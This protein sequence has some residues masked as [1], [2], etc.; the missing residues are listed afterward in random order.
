MPEPDPARI[1]SFATSKDIGRWLKTN[2]ATES[3]LW[4]KIFKKKTG[5]SSVTWD[6]VVIE[7]LCW[8]WIDGVKKSIDDQ[9]YLQRITPRK[10]RSNWSRRNRELVCPC[11]SVKKF[12]VP[13][14]ADFKL[15]STINRRT[16]KPSMEN[17]S[18]KSEKV[19]IGIDVHKSSYTVACSIDGVI[20][21][22]CRMK[23]SFVGLS[24]YLMKHFDGHEIYTVY[25]AGF[26][27]FELDRF[28]NSRGFK[29]IVINPGSVEVS[30]R[31]RV[32]TDKRDAKKLATQLACGRLK[33][34]RIPSREQ[35]QRR[36]L[37]RTRSQLIR[38]R[39][40]IKNQIRS[41]LHIFSLL[42][43]DDHR[44]MSFKLVGEVMSLN[45]DSELRT[46]LELLISIWKNID[47]QLKVLQQEIRK[48]AKKDPLE[49]VYR[50]LPGAGP[51]SARE[52]SN[53]LGDLQQF[54]NVK[55]LYSFTGLTPS[56]NSSGDKIRRGSISR[57]GSARL[58]HILVEMAWRAIRTDE[59]LR[60]DFNRIA[61]R[62]NK[63]KAIVAIAR[64]L[65][66][67]ARALFRTNTPY[68]TFCSVA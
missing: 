34:I 3:E 9:A 12:F 8:G 59:G 5:I 32:K 52:L 26:S 27:G 22:K 48:Q 30:S 67:R 57:Q 66:G 21:K 38:H 7:S 43:G 24:N 46:S 19:F 13:R 4:V 6:D 25:E 31:D 28:L 20:V 54:P 63:L 68:R 58:R 47:A 56:E 33:G 45:L 49:A 35:E 42:R 41:K 37:T 39:S 55:Q 23:A 65:I 14:N 29:N 11:G 60:R 15:I 18:Q 64:K 10:A 16:K 61:A 17:I 2:H 44:E 1:M 51:L 40:R 36:Q 50:Q 53:E 62:G